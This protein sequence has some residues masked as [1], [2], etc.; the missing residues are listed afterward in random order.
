ME[1]Q[2]QDRCT[3]CGAEVY[4]SDSSR[5]IRC[6]SCGNT[7]AVASFVRVQQQMEHQLAEGEK[8]RNALAAAQAEKEKAQASL[9]EAVHALDS[10]QNSQAGLN[11]RLDQLLAA[12][13]AGH[14]AWEK[15][16]VDELVKTY[17]QAEELQKER[18]FDEAEEYYRKGL[19]Q[20][21]NDPEVYWRLVLCHYCVEY[22]QDDEGKWIP[23]ILYPDLSDPSEVSVRTNL[24]KSART[25]G[26]G[27]E[28][29]YLE[30][31][32]AIDRILD[33]YRECH[34]RDRYDVFISVKQTQSGSGGKYYTEDYRVGRDL[35]DFL[36]SLGLKVFNSEKTRCPAGEEW[37]PYILS[38]LMSS[39][40]MIVV[41]TCP[42]YMESQWVRNEWSR[43]QWLQKNEKKKGESKQ[44]LLLCYLAGG[45]SPALIPKGLNPGRQAIIDGLMAQDEL[46]S[47]LSQVFP[48]L[49]Q[50]SRQPA[51]SSLQPAVSPK[52]AEPEGNYTFTP[53]SKGM[54]F[55]PLSI[56]QEN[57]GTIRLRFRGNGEGEMAHTFVLYTTDMEF[58]I[59]SFSNITQADIPMVTESYR[60]ELADG[61][62]LYCMAAMQNSD[63]AGISPGAEIEF[64][65]RSLNS[66]LSNQS[67]SRL[68]FVFYLLCGDANPRQKISQGLLSF[69]WPM[70]Q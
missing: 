36:S 31:L 50:V 58:E 49:G 4:Y 6:R 27:L 21:G 39:Q 12:Q 33:K 46:K 63:T 26:G 52:P 28:A 66:K 37:E 17:R 54:L 40:A 67:T 59:I 19:I 14:A 29:H 30:K 69:D 20:G 32:E 70:S 48:S 60:R 62:P 7:L 44:R 47:A 53:L 2:Y 34:N 41:G 16:R 64:R 57:G 51:E 8:A 24:L 5:L 10:I 15:S 25:A 56:Q 61:A 9:A 22:Q 43:Y 13:Q 1:A 68:R 18:R 23:S 11:E 38:A 45:M 65:I 42:E 35:Y 55:S 3:Y